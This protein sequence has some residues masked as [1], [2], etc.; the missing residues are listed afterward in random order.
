MQRALEEDEGDDVATNVA[1]SQIK[2]LM[3][4]NVME[5]DFSDIGESERTSARITKASYINLTEGEHAAQAYLKEHEPKWVIDHS[6]T[7]EH[8]MVCVNP[9]TKEI[10]MGMRGT[11]NA[12]EDMSTNIRLLFGQGAGAKQIQSLQK[13][14]DKIQVKYEKLPDILTGH[15]KGGGQAIFLGQDRGIDTHTQD[16]WV[17][18]QQLMEKLKSKHT[19]H[20]T[21]TDGVSMFANLTRFHDGFQ[22][23]EMKPMKGLSILQSHDGGRCVPREAPVPRGV[24]VPCTGTGEVV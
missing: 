14:I 22:V 17:K 8:A 11:T 13:T 24:P 19:I 23:H 3:S 2:G 16:P 6:L 10:R 4:R 15:S 1:K 7:T 21:P 5:R 20:R 9:E 18:P 12:G